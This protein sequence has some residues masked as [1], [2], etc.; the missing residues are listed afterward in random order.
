MIVNSVN[1]INSN[2]ARFKGIKD[3]IGS[4]VDT[5]SV[6]LKNGKKKENYTRKEINEG[7]LIG[8]IFGGVATFLAMHK[9]HS[10]RKLKDISARFEKSTGAELEKI[11]KKYHP[12]A[13][14]V[15]LDEIEKKLSIEKTKPKEI[16]NLVI[17][18]AKIKDIKT[19][20]EEPFG[21]KLWRWFDWI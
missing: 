21:E 11:L 6:A 15:L 10:F 20:S 14:D 3:N 2:Y 9:F 19:K 1:T 8:A 16:Q 12:D 5:I 7:L 13:R 18:I 17:E 4:D